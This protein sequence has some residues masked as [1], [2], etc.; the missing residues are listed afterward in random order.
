MTIYEYLELLNNYEIICS[1]FDC[2]TEELVAI[3]GETNF[4]RYELIQSDYADYEIF[5]M[6][7]WIEHNTIHIEFNIEVEEDYEY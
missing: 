2:N 5:S 6:D 3:D 1:L 4:G 7:M